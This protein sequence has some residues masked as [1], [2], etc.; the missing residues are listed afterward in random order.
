M[1]RGF[2]ALYCR[3]GLC[4][5]DSLAFLSL[6]SARTFEE[7]SAMWLYAIQAILGC[8]DGGIPYL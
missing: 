8:T 6:G 5:G 4:G 7:C 3:G 2:F 1:E